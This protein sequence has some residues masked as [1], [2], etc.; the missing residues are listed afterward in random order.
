MD[1][2]EES[3]QRH[4]LD[5][6]GSW[7][8]KFRNYALESL[9]GGD[10]IVETLWQPKISKPVLKVGGR[11]FVQTTLSLAHVA[12]LTDRELIIIQDDERSREIRG[13]RYG[14]KRQYI[15][16]S[17]ISGV[18]RPDDA[19]DLVRLC[20]TLSPGGRQMEII[21]SA[22]RKEQIAQLQDELEKLIG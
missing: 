4:K 2:R 19:G 3:E 12:I 13:V 8:L 5:Y 21:F 15:A 20:L 6:L 16:L 17:H 7:S 11:V 9:V 22:S 10:K 14:G 18:S 1:E